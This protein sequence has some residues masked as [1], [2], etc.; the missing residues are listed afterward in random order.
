[1]KENIYKKISDKGLISKIYK[2]LLYLH[3]EEKYT[4][5]AN[6]NLADLNRHFIN[7]GTQM[8]NSYMERY[9][10]TLFITKV[11]INAQ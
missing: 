5:K 2:E 6:K 8:S 11:K 1:M 7:E 3:S 4:N 9:S 10:T